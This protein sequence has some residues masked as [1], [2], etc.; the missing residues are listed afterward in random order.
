MFQN[1]LIVIHENDVNIYYRN[2]LMFITDIL[3]KKRKR[4]LKTLNNGRCD[5]SECQNL[6]L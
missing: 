2:S 4:R 3:K 1:S 5:K 6:H